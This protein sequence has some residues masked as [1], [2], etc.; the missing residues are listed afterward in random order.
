MAIPT[1]DD[2][3]GIFGGS[4]S[5]SLYL[6]DI[7]ADSLTYKI[8]PPECNVMAIYGYDEKGGKDGAGQVI[9][10]IAFDQASHDGA[11][12]NP[13]NYLGRWK[14]LTIIDS[15]MN[16]QDQLQ[17]V[18]TRTF[19]VSRRA[20]VEVQWK[21][22]FD[23]SVKTNCAVELD[24]I[25]LVQVKYISV[26]A[27]GIPALE[28][29][30]STTYKG[31]LLSDGPS[32]LASQPAWLNTGSTI[33]PDHAKFS[34]SVIERAA[35]ACSENTDQKSQTEAQKKGREAMLKKIQHGEI[36]YGAPVVF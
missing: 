1:Y 25:G 5:A 7:D 24:G 20:V 18:I 35:A 9:G 34:E 26:E 6:G 27:T 4:R 13:L 10:R 21:A 28:N 30:F 23:S 15:A 8:I 32:W 22:C 11:T 12:P 33:K 19:E 14:H 3:Q 36:S 29:T 2:I 17:D 16:T 31:I